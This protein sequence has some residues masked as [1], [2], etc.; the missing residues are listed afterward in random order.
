MEG[1][2]GGGEGW[3][4]HRIMSRGREECGDE[5]GL[6]GICRPTLL[7]GPKYGCSSMDP[8]AEAATRQAG[9]LG[10]AHGQAWEAGVAEH[11]AEPASHW[12]PAVPTPQRNHPLA[13]FLDE[14]TLLLTPQIHPSPT[15]EISSTRST[16]FTLFENSPGFWGATRATSYELALRRTNIGG[17]ETGTPGPIPGPCGYQSTSKTLNRGLLLLLCFCC[18]RA[19]LLERTSRPP[20]R[21]IASAGKEI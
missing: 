10:Q 20:G 1:G 9:R 14:M 15:L 19:D 11:W 13:R 5:H 12:R 2:G 21:G 6:Q 7:T 18:C 4:D 8:P 16:V 17:I 3:L